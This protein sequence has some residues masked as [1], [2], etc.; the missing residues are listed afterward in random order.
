MGSRKYPANSPKYQFSAA[1]GA[2][3]TKFA[4]HKQ[5]TSFN[6]SLIHNDSYKLKPQT[7]STEFSLAI[8]AASNLVATQITTKNTSLTPSSAATNYKLNW[9]ENLRFEQN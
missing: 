3:P 2:T 8:A 4:K 7:K 5:Q 9:S 1:L 6:K